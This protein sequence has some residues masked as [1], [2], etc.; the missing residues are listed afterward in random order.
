MITLS[1]CPTKLE[2][3]AQATHER[4]DN[5]EHHM[6]KEQKAQSKR[7]C[8]SCWKS[9]HM[10]HSCPLGNNSKLISFNDHDDSSWFDWD[11]IVASCD[12]TA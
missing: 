12:R 10:A 8:Y 1:K 7:K 4:Q 6:S 3:K 11:D 2:K 9:G 5:E